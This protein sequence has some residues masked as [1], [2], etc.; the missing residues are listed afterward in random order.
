[1]GQAWWDYVQSGVEEWSS[2][3]GID[4]I[5]KGPT[6]VDAAAQVQI[7][8]DIVN[9]GVDILCFSPNDPHH[10]AICKRSQRQR[11]NRHATEASGMN[12]DYDVEALMKLA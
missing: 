7:M 4:V 6:E 8:T 10:E 12:I 11:H 2:E 9:Q 3:K 1:M 5:Y